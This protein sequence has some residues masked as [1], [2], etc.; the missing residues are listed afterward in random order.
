M[1]APRHEPNDSREWPARAKSNLR[2]AS[3][4]DEAVYPEELCYNAQQ[5]AEKAIK[6]VFVK[7]G[8]EFPYTHNLARLLNLL[9]DLK[10]VE[11]PAEV[12]RA[13]DLTRFA[14]E[15]RYPYVAREVTDDQYSE[16]LQT[17]DAVVCWAEKIIQ[18]G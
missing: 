9:V 11:V 1:S 5:A 7:L 3:V 14:A 13:E 8:R 12:A 15:A 4:R 6:G 2:L 10:V 16:A 18:G 17:A